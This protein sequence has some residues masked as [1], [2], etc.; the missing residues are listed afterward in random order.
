MEVLC[1]NRIIATHERVEPGDSHS[2]AR[3]DL[4]PRT[5]VARMS[6]SRNKTRHPLTLTEVEAQIRRDLLDFPIRDEFH[7][8]RKHIVRNS[9]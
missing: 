6:S 5:R 3:L 4:P 2:A 9:G 8:I 1:V 7:A